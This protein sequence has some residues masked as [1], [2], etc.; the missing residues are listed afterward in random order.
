MKRLILLLFMLL[1]FCLDYA[2]SQNTIIGHVS[3]K[4]D[5]TPLSN[6]LIVMK[7]KTTSSIIRYTQ[8][9]IEGGN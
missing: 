5:Q 2:F 4:A 3:D 8:T 1:I 9:S 6:V 7:S